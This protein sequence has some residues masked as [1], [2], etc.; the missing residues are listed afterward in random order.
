MIVFDMDG[1]LIDVSKSYRHA[2]RETAK[3]FFQE[4]RRREDLPDPL[5]SLS[6]LATVQQS[7]G[8]NNDWDL[9]CFII[10]LLFDLVR[11]LKISTHP[12]P[13]L[14]YQETVRCCEAEGLARFLKS[15]KRP[16]SMLLEKKKKP[17]NDFILSLY[18]NDVGS[19]NIIKQIFQE[20]YLGNDLFRSIYGLAPAVFHGKGLIGL[21]EPLINR[22]DLQWL[23]KN[24]LLAIATGRPRIEAEHPLNHFGMKENFS[25]IYTLDDCLREEKRILHDQGLKVCL[26][27]PDP[28]MLDAIAARE[29]DSV[30]DCYY[31]GDMPDDMEAAVRST[32]GFVGLGFLGSAPDKD[33]LKTGLLRSGAQHIIKDVKELKRFFD[34]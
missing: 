27:K 11:P 6:D 31:I 2:V 16:L 12:D 28:Y 29:R 4:A 30:S 34:Q 1:V 15:S 9:T 22:P 5:F 24:N 18:T 23:A 33:A 26:S 17:D 25:A 21:E 20:I 13:W 14:R 7:G 10:D 8:L 32:N 3:L 19:G